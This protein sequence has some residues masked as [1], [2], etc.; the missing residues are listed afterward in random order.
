MIKDLTQLESKQKGKIIE[1]PNDSKTLKKLDALG[2]RVGIE[3]LKLS[4]IFPKGP[5]IIQIGNTQIALSHNI[6][7]KIKVEIH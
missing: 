5:V 7:K 2:I 3:V 4:S 6:A 1:I